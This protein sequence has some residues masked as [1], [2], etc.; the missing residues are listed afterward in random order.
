MMI[1]TPI[2]G[3][4][5]GTSTAASTASNGEYIDTTENITVWDRSPISL[6]A[7]TSATG[8]VTVDNLWLGAETERG[9]SSLHRD[10]LAVFETNEEIPLTFGE[11]T[12]TS[13]FESRDDVQLLTGYLEEDVSEND[14]SDVPTTGQE[15]MDELTSKNIDN[16]NDNVS[17]SLNHSVKFDGDGNL[18]TPVTP[19]KP[20]QYMY[21]LATGDNL[22]ATD[23]DGDG[24]KDDLEINGETTIVGVEQLA[25]QN[26]PSDVTAP[27]SAEPG[28]DIDFNVNAA[29]LS[30][31]TS[32]SVVLYEEN[33]FTKSTMAVNISEQLSKDLSTEDVTI[34]HDIKEVN[35]VQN[36]QDDVT[37]FGQS[38]ESRTGTGLVQFGNVVSFLSNNADVDEPG[39]QVSGDGISLDASS[40]AV[41]ADETTTL[42]V[43]TY[44]NWTETDYR[45]I[46]VASG[47]SSDQI[48]VNTGMLEVESSGGGGGDDDDGDP[49]P[50]PGDGDDD[51]AT[52]TE[53]EKSTPVVDTEKGKATASF[54]KTNVEQ[55][56]FD[57]SDI[58]GDVTS[59]DLDREPNE[60][61]PSPGVSAS[62]S[63]IVVPDN[64]KN[65]SA[66]IR[67]KV[68]TARLEEIDADAEDLRVNRY[69]DE[70]GKW[71]GLQT[72]LVEK[73]D[74]VVVLEAETPGF[75]YFSVSAVSEPAADATA[76]S[77]TID[78]G[79]EVELDGSSSE[80]R[81]GEI[82]DYQWEI[83]DQTLSGETVTTT[84]TES[85]EY[86]AELTV[87]NDADEV[88]SDSVT[89]TVEGE[90]GDTGDS[91]GSGEDGDGD[92]DGSDSDGGGLLPV[93]G[94]GLIVTVVALS[95]ALLA[96]RRQ[97]S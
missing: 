66:T 24:K 11:H 10:T 36:L 67:T 47:S 63:E 30:G 4:V 96:L 54:E 40:T 65:T 35:G 15:L 77:T 37:F 91:D 31:E 86:T 64:A 82:V 71:Q 16:L 1:L 9:D 17:F 39:T 80:N 94:F 59:R 89:I 27:N 7:N 26:S 12:D 85:G 6:R 43:E 29:E 18:T 51:N 72:T 57:S 38:L 76:S 48:Q 58:T 93:P 42:T 92:S 81:Y 8:A 61:G 13:N 3:V 50:T 56:V 73:R 49:D 32:H 90:G 78:A 53:E 14:L 22:E 46:H 33:S 2:A 28:E 20:G 84:L 95:V 52:V 34:K 45:W 23:E 74:D 69:N 75:S 5:G 19:D 83:G 88:D 21:V 79:G 68:S 70:K 62:V 97:S 41:Q 55:I 25:A 60:T 44:D 87:T